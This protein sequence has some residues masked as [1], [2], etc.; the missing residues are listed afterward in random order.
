MFDWV[1][2]P[3]GPR[4]LFSCLVFV[5]AAVLY[6]LAVVRLRKT[7]DEDREIVRRKR[8][9]TK[10]SLILASIVV[11]GVVWAEQISHLGLSLAA[12]IVAIVLATKELSLNLLGGVYLYL[13][14]AF[15]VGDKIQ[16]GNLRGDVINVGLFNFTLLEVGPTE[17]F[18]QFTGKSITVPLSSLI[19]IPPPSIINESFHGKF[20]V[21]H[22]SVA[23]AREENL[24]R[25]GQLLISA[26]NEVCSEFIAEAQEN[27]ERLSSK[28]FI[29]TPDVSPRVTFD[30][31][32]ADVSI[33][34][35]RFPAPSDKKGKVEQRIKQS[36]LQ[37]LGSAEG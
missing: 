29:E 21:H 5:L 27:M 24:D 6:R 36:Y 34:L 2:S 26:A 4:I 17:S 10:N 14:K 22:C 35:L 30:L 32:K 25:H 19:C 18:H 3:L 7:S 20:V 11:F 9:F 16:V 37:S 15:N 23:L 13:T 28:D 31:S 8:V 12:F 33:I 1:H